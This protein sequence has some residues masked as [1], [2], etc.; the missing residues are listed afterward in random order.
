MVDVCQRYRVRDG[1]ATL[2]LLP[3]N[4]CWGL[5]VKPNTETFQ[6]GLDDLL[7]PERLEDIQD[8]EYEVTCPRNW[9]IQRG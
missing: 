8:N 7:I 9:G 5:L 3:N 1:Y 2:V 4:N 6:L